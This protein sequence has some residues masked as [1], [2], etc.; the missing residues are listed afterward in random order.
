M[1]LNDALRR[2]YSNNNSQD[3][4]I[5]TQWIDLIN[6]EVNAWLNVLMNEESNKIFKRSDIDKLIELIDVLPSGFI[7]CEQTGCHFHILKA[8][9]IFII[10]LSTLCEEKTENII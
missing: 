3:K 7:A 9:K 8:S 4:K 1:E 2:M 6:I 10:F 5:L